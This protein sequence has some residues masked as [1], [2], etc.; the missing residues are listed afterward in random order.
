MH[1]ILG[2]SSRQPRAGCRGFSLV[3]LVV[4]MVVLTMAFAMY[5]GIVIATA[6]QRQMLRESALAG[7]ACQR[8]M[9]SIR[10]CDLDQVYALY[11]RS[12]ADDPAGPGTA[13]GSRFPVVGL[14]P[15]PTLGGVV[16]EVLMPE[17][18]VSPGVWQLREDIP[19]AELGMP[20]DLNGDS[21]IDDKDHSADYVHVPTLVR[22]RWGGARGSRR[23]ELV[24]LRTEYRR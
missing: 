22:V 20:R 8:W 15:D 14:D 16:G 19:N 4:T 1:P 17:V 24:G 12:P 7:D 11:N 10:S 5:S 3:E 2:R 6:R 18:E 21:I 23:F 9:E 13:P